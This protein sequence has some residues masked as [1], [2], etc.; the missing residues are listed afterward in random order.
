MKALQIL[1]VGISSVLLSCGPSEYF[2]GPDIVTEW[3]EDMK[4]LHYENKTYLAPPEWIIGMWY[5]D[6]DEY[7][8]A[9]Q[10]T[11]SDV[12]SYYY[13]NGLKSF[14]QNKQ[15]NKIRWGEH[16]ST[17]IEQIKTDTTYFYSVQE[18]TSGKPIYNK[19]FQKISNDSII[20]ILSGHT[21]DTIK[22]GRRY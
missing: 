8:R 21:T 16:A 2:D 3:F 17:L 10:F 14:S 9:V 18:N 1:L 12:I 19:L 11:Y 5:A 13:S 4:D 6:D 20:N 22:Y 15:L 7:V